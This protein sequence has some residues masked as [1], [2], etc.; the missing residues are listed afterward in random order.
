MVCYPDCSQKNHNHKSTTWCL[1]GENVG[2]VR[3]SESPVVNCA[4]TARKSELAGRNN[5]LNSIQSINPSVEK[6]IKDL[7]KNAESQQ[8]HDELLPLLYRFQAIFD[9]TKHN[10]AKTSISHII[11]IMPHS[12]PACRP[13]PQPRHEEALYNIIQ[14]FLKAGLITESSSP[15]AASVMLVD[16]GDGKKRLV[17]DYKKLNRVTIKD[18]SPMPN[19]EETIRKLGKRYNYFSKL[20]LKSG[21][22]L[23]FYQIPIRE[24][25][26]EKTAFVTPFGHYQFNVL[27]MGLKNSPPTFQ[28]VMNSTL[29]HCRSFSLVYVDDIIVFS[30]TFEEHLNHLQQVFSTLNDKQIV[31]SPPKCVIAVQKIDYLGHTIT[32]DT[33][34]PRN[35]KIEAILDIPEPKT[36]SQANK[37]IGATGWY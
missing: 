10:I 13:H 7:I 29:K 3:K 36:L 2:T 33:I 14:E 23:I 15:Y 32:K 16:K 27:P 1:C 4:T 24:A 30:H 9:T 22:Y 34:T 8:Q 25:D 35:E 20:D 18:S 5:A 6:E 31:L 19:M 28:K 21:F 11:N 12:P 26:K 37:F 17:V